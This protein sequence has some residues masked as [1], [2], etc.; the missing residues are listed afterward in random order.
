MTMDK[1]SNKWNQVSADAQNHW[2]KLTEQDLAQVKGNVQEMVNLVQDR[3]GYTRQRAEQDVTQFL[4]KYDAK[5][6]NVANSLPGD[7][8]A[9]IMRR[10]WATLATA[11]GIGLA[12]GMAFRPGC[13][14]G[15]EITVDIKGVNR[16]DWS[17]A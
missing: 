3:Y 9:K 8:P 7:V 11:L 17:P 4:D 14:D 15:K 16:S 1:L 2:S 10:P 13:K 5:I 6:Y 12:L